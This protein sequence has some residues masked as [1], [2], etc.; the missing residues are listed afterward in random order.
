MRT[1]KLESLTEDV[2]NELLM[3][4]VEYADIE[5]QVIYLDMDHMD[6]LEAHG[7]NIDSTK[8][9]I[10]TEAAFFKLLNCC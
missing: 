3:N 7:I 9:E 2:Q 4:G 1:I 5:G 8:P 6:I 10:N